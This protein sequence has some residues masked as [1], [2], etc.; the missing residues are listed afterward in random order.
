M[1]LA[2]WIIAALLALFYIYAGGKKV[3]QSQEQLQPMMA[4]VD[5]VSMPL[6]RTIGY[7]RSSARPA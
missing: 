3:T 2:H 1:E 6:V 4:W 7:W 5:S